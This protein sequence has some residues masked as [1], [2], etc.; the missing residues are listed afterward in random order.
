MNPRLRHLASALLVALTLGALIVPAVG[1]EP[2]GAAEPFPPRVRRELTKALDS[3][4]GT[5]V[6]PGAIVG[7][8]VGDRAWTATRGST[9][10]GAKAAPTLADHTRIGS[11]TKTFTGT[12]ILELADEGKLALS[13]TIDKWLPWV[14]NANQI[15]VH[16]LGNMSSGINTYTADQSFLDRYFSTPMAPWKPIEVIRDGVSLPSTFAPGK[17]FFYSNTNFMLL[18][19]IAERV[20]GESVGRLFREHIFEPLGMTHTSYPGTIFLASPFW[21]GYTKQDATGEG[22]TIRDATHWNPTGFGAAGQIV[23]TVGDMKL[24]AEGIGTGALLTK[25]GRRTQ[26]EANPYAVKGTRAYAFGVGTD[27][28]WLTH[29]GTV[30]GYNTDFAYLPKLHASI[31][32]LTNTDTAAEPGGGGPAPAITSALSEVIAP[33]DVVH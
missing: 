17:G 23:S 2:S 3:S 33:G 20:T 15:T 14:P 27:N 11:L 8:W 29:A 9:R 18:G 4:F 7:V 1:A 32:V 16:E 19:A 30:P 24:F 28:G 26:V 10:R 31:V 13:D 21:H 25:A 12:L 22:T 5:T 6:S